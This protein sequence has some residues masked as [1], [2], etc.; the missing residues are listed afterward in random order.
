SQAKGQK[1]VVLAHVKDSSQTLF[2]MY[3]RCHDNMPEML[4]PHTRYSSRREIVFDELD[5]GVTVT[6]AGGDSPLRGETLQHMHLSEVAFWPS[7]FAKEN[8]SGL[9]KAL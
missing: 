4:K 5:S 6:T 1:A 7:S 8:F 3:R 2:D 9:V